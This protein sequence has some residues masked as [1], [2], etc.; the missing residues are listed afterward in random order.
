MIGWHHLQMKFA[1]DKRTLAPKSPILSMFSHV[2]LFVIKDCTIAENRVFLG[3][4]R[5]VGRKGVKRLG[6][7][8]AQCATVRSEGH[9]YAVKKVR[10]AQMKSMLTLNAQ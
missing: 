5:G 9:D 8:G 3:V 1:H 2:R 7:G 6:I 4:V 10:E